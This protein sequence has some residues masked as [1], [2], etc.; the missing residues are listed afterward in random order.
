[1]ADTVASVYI[2]LHRPVESFAQTIDLTCRPMTHTSDL[3]G[4]ADSADKFGVFLCR[5]T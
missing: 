2:L 5:P 3:G 1:L 4:A